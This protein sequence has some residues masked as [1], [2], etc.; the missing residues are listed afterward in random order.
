MEL[1]CNSAKYARKCDS[2]IYENHS[3]EQLKKA[4]AKASS[5]LRR[6]RRFIPIDKL[7]VLY[8]AFILPHLEYCGPLLLGIGKVQSDRLDDANHC[9]LRTLLGHPWKSV[10][11]MNNY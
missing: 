2:Q 1:E 4:Y 3:T 6:N 5:A 8:K 7:I 9:I 11:Y 10:P